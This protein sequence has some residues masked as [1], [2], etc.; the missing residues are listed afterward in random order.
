MLRR[1]NL[2]QQS[3]NGDLTYIDT[4]GTWS[5]ED[6]TGASG[7]TTP[8]GLPYGIPVYLGSTAAIPVTL[9]VSAASG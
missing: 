1:I 6:T 7:G 9:V 5:V 3:V 2:C 4:D 8:I